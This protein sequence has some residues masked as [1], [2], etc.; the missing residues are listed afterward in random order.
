MVDV[1]C[2]R[3]ID[4]AVVKED[5]GDIAVALVSSRGKAVLRRDADERRRIVGG[6]LETDTVDVSSAEVARLG[7]SRMWRSLSTTDA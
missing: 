4:E 7:E 5:C 2:I 3:K 1:A 6:R